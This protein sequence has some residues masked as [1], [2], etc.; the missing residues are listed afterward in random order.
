MRVSIVQTSPI[1][2]NIQSNIKEALSAMESEEADLFVLPE[3]FNTGYNF[4]DADEVNKL[5]E[6]IEGVTYEAIAE[7]TNRKRCYVAYGFA[8]K[9][10]HIY[11]SSA[12]VGPTGLAGLYRK[13]H[14]YNREHLFFAPGNLGF[15][16]FDIPF[17]KIGMMICFDWIFP[18]SA[19]SLALHGAQLIVHPSN[20]VMPY[21]PDAMVTRCLENRVF[22]A[23][24]NRVGKESRGGVQFKYIG[25]SEVVTP[26]GEILV[27]LNSDQSGISVVEIDLELAKNKKLNEYNDLLQDRKPDQYTVS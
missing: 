23:T 17:G 26:K 13:V 1:F 14:L 20:L 4:I 5:S 3:L 12:L 7:F 21:C 2:G 25:K 22:A 27:R 19:R 11:N 8:E 16:V 15:P 9:S 24:A 6:P 18:E 10:D